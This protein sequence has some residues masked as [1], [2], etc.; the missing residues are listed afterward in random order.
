M[1]LSGAVRGVEQGNRFRPTF[2]C[3][4]THSIGKK[5]QNSPMNKMRKIRPGDIVQID[6]SLMIKAKYDRGRNLNTPNRWVFGAYDPI[7]KQGYIR[8]IDRRDALTLL[9]IIEEV[10]LPGSIICS[11]EWAA[12]NGIPQ[13]PNMNYTHQTVNHS[14]NFVN[15][16]TGIHT[17]NVEN[18][19]KRVKANFKRMNG[20][21]DGFVEGYLDE[22]VW[23]ERFG[24][25]L[26]LAYENLLRQTNEKQPC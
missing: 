8:F 12:C 7:A 25:T 17:Y 2:K 10:I 21:K 15:P 14:Q 16:L 4:N 5:L 24:P 13:I 26:D 6:E 1:D 22:F 19:W 23:R 3:K 20:T 9:P 11:E 18:Y